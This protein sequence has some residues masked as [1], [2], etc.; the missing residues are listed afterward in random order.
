[1][2]DKVTEIWEN[3]DKQLR[4][5]ICSKMNNNDECLDVLQDVYLKIIKNIDKIG[6]VENMPSYLNKLASNAVIDHYRQRSKKPIS[7]NDNMAEL[8]IIDE[9]NK[10]EEELKNCCLQCL[11]PGINTLP[12]KYKEALI[13]S[14]LEGMPQKEVA[15][16]LGIT[17][18]GAKS[19][20]QRAREKLRVEIIRCCY[21][22]KS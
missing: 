5:L 6:A 19:R 12:G 20:V 9:V 4:G 17:L 13:L 16:K 18:S 3:F 22:Q 10:D 2:E 1:V 21:N 7:G 15:E 14:E 11:E 8:V